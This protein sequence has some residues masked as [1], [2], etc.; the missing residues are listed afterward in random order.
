MIECPYCGL[1]NWTYVQ[2]YSSTTIDR[3]NVREFRHVA[4]C[5]CNNCGRIFYFFHTRNQVYTMR[6][7]D[8]ELM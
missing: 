1:P 6:L 4:L 3:S 5:R 8:V 7:E 2:R